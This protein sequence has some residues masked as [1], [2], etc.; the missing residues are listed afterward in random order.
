MA[1]NRFF[2]EYPWSSSMSTLS[3]RLAAIVDAL[4]L[5]PGMRVL[6]I[7][8]APGAAAKEVV[9]RI[10]DGHVMVIDRSARG[11]AQIERTCTAEIASGRLSVRCVAVEDF[12]LLP[13]EERFDLAFAVRVGALDGRHPE[14]GKRALSK[15]AA[16]LKP[17]GVLLIDTGTPLR[18]I[19]VPT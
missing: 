6:E 4:S 17:D 3:P 10:G 8:G 13:G 5:R 16:A 14:T 15:I 1:G 12:T 2:G 9:R 11:V 19:H 7:G 18:Q